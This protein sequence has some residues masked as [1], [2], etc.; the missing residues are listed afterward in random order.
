MNV[1]IVYA[2]PEPRSFNGAMKDLAVD[3]LTGAGHKVQVS[4]LYAMNFNAAGGPNDFTDR[5]Y[6]DRFGYQAEQ[7]AG[8]F[9]PEL[10]EEM[11][12]L[13]WCDL[14]ILQFPLWWFSLPGILKGWIDRVFAFGFAYDR[15]R[16]YESGMFRG[17]CGMLSFT[18]GAPAAAYQADGRHGSID[19]LLL[20]VN[21]G[22]LYFLGMDVL[23]PFIA[24]GTPRC[25]EA[26]LDAYLAAY[27]ERL[28][29]I[30][31]IQPVF[32]ASAAASRS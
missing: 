9:A 32:T 26:E 8:H 13:A 1:L 31:S 2:H 29:N 25:S 12:K 6:P 15:S 7:A 28:L 24:Y 30:E 4:D 14:L 16:S 27:R 19:E 17:K 10:R 21:R 23:P 11:D 18:T 20:H 5:A 22:M 3:V